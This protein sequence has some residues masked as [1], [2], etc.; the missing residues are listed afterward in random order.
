M[1]AMGHY[2]HYVFGSDVL[3][4]DIIPKAGVTYT[5]KATVTAV[6]QV[7]L[8][9]NYDP[10]IID[11]RYGTNTANAIKRMQADAGIPQTGVIDSGVLM[12]LGISAKGP[13]AQLPDSIPTPMGRVSLAPIG[14]PT[15]AVKSAGVRVPPWKIG[16][17]IGAGVAFLAALGLMSFSVRR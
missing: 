7:L 2:D 4:E 5:D 13:G 8:S 15:P 16:L 3:G 11:G 17:S 10:G 6:Q 1:H 14:M 12:A 9:R